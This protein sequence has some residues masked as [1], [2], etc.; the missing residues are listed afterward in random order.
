[1]LQR[2]YGNR[3]GPGNRVSIYL[4]SAGLGGISWPEFRGTPELR[5][6]PNGNRLRFDGRDS[7]GVR[8]SLTH[9]R[10]TSTIQRRRTASKL[11]LHGHG[12][13][14][15]AAE[16]IPRIFAPVDCFVRFLPVLVLLRN[17]S[18]STRPLPPSSISCSCAI[19]L[20]LEIVGINRSTMSCLPFI[21][22]EAKS[23]AAEVGFQS[24]DTGCTH[25]QKFRESLP[26]QFGNHRIRPKPAAKVRLA[27]L[28]LSNLQRPNS[29]ERSS[30]GPGS[31]MAFQGGEI[32]RIFALS[33]AGEVPGMRSQWRIRFG[34]P[35]GAAAR[36][37]LRVH[38]VG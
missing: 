20:R 21:I 23:P 2:S 3:F 17:G 13:A 7:V 36:G 27:R 11:R 34:R 5:H 6:Q 9:R 22:M 33:A 12:F 10:D 31:P 32:S 8:C 1:V 35:F 26:P 30:R 19:D 29:A 38:S 37:R 15:D 25:F 28:S 18:L 14:P 24:H 16:K 4:R